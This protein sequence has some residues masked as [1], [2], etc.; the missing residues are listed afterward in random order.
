[1]RVELDSEV[2][3]DLVEILEYYDEQAGGGVAA[4]FYAEFRQYAKAAGERP[5]SFPAHEELRRVNLQ[6]FPHHFLFQIMNEKT[7]RILVVKHNHRNPSY[8]LDRK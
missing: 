7:L 2:Y 8:G 3:I 4:D 1:M 5:Y 6:K